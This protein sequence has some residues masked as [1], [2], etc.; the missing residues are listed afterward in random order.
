[1]TD[2]LLTVAQAA[3]RLGLT[4]RA[5]NAAIKRGTLPASKPPYTLGTRTPWLIRPDDLAAY[6]AARA[7]RG[8]PGRKRKEG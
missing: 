5:I 6:V 1:M 8:K 3:Q 7:H 4:V 2:D